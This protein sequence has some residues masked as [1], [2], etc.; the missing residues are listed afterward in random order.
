MGK[1]RDEM[2]FTKSIHLCIQDHKKED[3]EKHN[4]QYNKNEIFWWKQN[5]N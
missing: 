5:K 1:K 2:K 3:G 4:W